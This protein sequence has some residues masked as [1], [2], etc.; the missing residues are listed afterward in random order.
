MTKKEQQELQQLKYDLEMVKALSWPNFDYPTPIPVEELQSLPCNAYRE[1]YTFNV[2]T[3]CVEKVWFNALQMYTTNPDT[4]TTYQS[5][6]RI[7]ALFWRTKKEACQALI[8]EMAKA[9]GTCHGL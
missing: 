4:H 6:S 5:G 3:C 7:V 1:G 9:Y 2:H 8:I